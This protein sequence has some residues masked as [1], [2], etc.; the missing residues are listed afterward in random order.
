MRRLFTIAAL[1]FVATTP[2]AAQTSADA[3]L[4]A[5]IAKKEKVRCT[6]EQPVG[7]RLGG[8]KVCR[9]ESESRDIREQTRQKMDQTQRFYTNGS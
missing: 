1:T 8:R 4:A 7:S 9:T 6:R 5:G 2:V 3:A